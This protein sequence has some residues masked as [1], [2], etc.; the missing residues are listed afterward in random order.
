MLKFYN[1]RRKF[2]L[3]IVSGLV[4]AVFFV[5]PDV[6]AAQAA[7]PETV[8]LMNSVN[9]LVNYILKFSSALLWPV[10][11][12]IGSLLDNELIFGGAM[13]E[14]L[15]G[16]W[17][18]VRNI[19][20]IAF[21][22][23]LL[24]V[25]VYNVLGIGEE[26]GPF[27]LKQVLPKFVLAL[28]AVNFSFLAI[29]VALDF[30]NVITGAVFALP[31]TAS[32]AEFKREQIED[33]I[34]GT[35]SEEVPMK[36]LWCNEK[37]FNDRAKSM[38]SRL[39][40]TNVALVYAIKFGNAPQMKFIKDGLKDLSQLGFNILFNMVL[41]VVY[42]LSFVVL[43]LVLLSRVVAMWIA[44]VLSPLLALSIVVPQLKELGGG[45][46]E[47]QQKFVKGAIAPITIGLVLSVG[48]IMLDGFSADKSI[49]GALLS[50][51]TL[52]AIDPNALPT[53]ITDLQQLMV[54]VGIVVIVWTGVF[55]AAKD[56][57][58]GT[59]TEMIRSK[60][61]DFGKWTAKLPTFLQAIPTGGKFGKVS[62]GQ[63]LPTLQKK[64]QD[65]QMAGTRPLGEGAPP[66]SKDI[67]LWQRPKYTKSM[68][69]LAQAISE[70]PHVMKD[71]QG[72]E[73][74]RDAIM[75]AKG[76]NND[77]AGRKK[78][79]DTYGRG[80]QDIE[81][82]M[83]PAIS[84]D[85]ALMARIRRESKEK[86]H[87]ATS[88]RAAI[89]RKTEEPIDSKQ[90]AAKAIRERDERELVENPVLLSAGWNAEQIK[91]LKK[92]FDKIPQTLHES[93]L[94]W[95]NDKPTF[96]EGLDHNKVSALANLF[97]VLKTAA[98]PEDVTAA[99]TAARATV[100]ENWVSRAVNAATNDRGVDIKAAAAPAT[101]GAAA[102]RPGQPTA[103]P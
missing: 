59:V 63:L 1:Q 4:I 2:C 66:S 26:G 32:D 95:K 64:M 41:Y 10:L 93:M 19:V 65:I 67:E 38:F 94:D 42:A 53:G 33:M 36:G 78:F 47:L 71:S 74:V 27:A 48:Y 7:D 15:L 6:A 56:T 12:M 54:A 89:E 80:P 68:D 37:K 28:I 73:Y 69:H 21:V 61:V 102:G 9:D 34:C 92:D 16:I 20:N 50:S 5:I 76:I 86:I 44:V 43:F 88:L 87:D 72:W 77:E 62:I 79:E 3:A 57:V 103:R 13:G 83:I 70:S 96:T 52:G 45:A 8:K 99:I 29:K 39:D 23:V 22:L 40:R 35:T 51:S 90:A 30:T 75:A 84:G 85:S 24:A 55:G 97:N 17:V 46:G 49:H 58:A 11:L 31:A 25:A 14:R 101:T 60:A 98:T 100:G 82:K 81:N 91:Q 18:Q